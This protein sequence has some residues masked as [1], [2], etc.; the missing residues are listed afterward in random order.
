[1]V[2]ASVLPRTASADER[3]FRPRVEAAL[4]STLPLSVGIAGHVELPYRL[5]LALEVGWVQP[6]YVALAND[7]VV[8]AGGYDRAT[9]RI[10]QAALADSV[11]LRASGGWRPFAR[12]G[13]EVFAGYTLALL[14]GGRSTAEMIESLS[15]PLREYAVVEVPGGAAVHAFHVG[16]GWRFDV[17][18]RLTLRV[19]LAYLQAFAASV[20]V[21]A[22]AQRPGTEAFVDEAASTAEKHLEHSLVTWLKAP[23]LGVFVA[24]RF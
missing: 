11:L 18:E 17:G 12:A 8:A 15:D 24:W 16:A 21:Q 13:F 3:R 7:V 9:A 4:G 5:L 23:A 1:M 10:V 19:S 14:G 2:L 6:G 20:D 22:L